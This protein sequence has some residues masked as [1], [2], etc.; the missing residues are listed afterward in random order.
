MHRQSLLL[1]GGFDFLISV[2]VQST[3]E[4]PPPALPLLIDY[5][6][7]SFLSSLIFSVTE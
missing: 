2:L 4:L 3:L 7:I 6:L 1:G 5:F